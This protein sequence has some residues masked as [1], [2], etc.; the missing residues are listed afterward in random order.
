M[1]EKS[2]TNSRSLSWRHGVVSVNALGGMLGSTSFILPNGRQ[3]SPFHI[4]PW[5]DDAAVQADGGMLAGLRGEWPCVPFGYP[6]PS[7]EYPAHWPGEIEAS[8]EVEH[9]HGFSANTDWKFGPEQPDQIT[10]SIDYPEDHAIR[11]LHRIIKPDPNSAALDI[12]LII[13]SRHVSCEPI[14]LH[15]CFA[16]PLTVGQAKIETSGF[17]YGRTHPATVEPEA[18]IFASNEMF[19]SLEAVPTRTGKIQDASKLP[20]EANGEDLLQLDGLTGPVSLRNDE[21]G[22]RIAFDWDQNIL[23]SLLIWYSNRGRSAPPWNNQHLCIG[24]EPICSPFGMSPDMARAKNP[25]N[26]QGIPTCVPLSPDTPLTIRY[27]FEISQVEAV[28]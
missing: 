10:L 6:F 19:N 8:A 1:T 9:P 11:R 15:G 24:L 25:I 27:R 26:A 21:A 13:E 18:P 3:V 5:F 14:A 17:E 4:A 28:Q 12:E 7:D 2:P 23:P 22:F 16:L 20:L